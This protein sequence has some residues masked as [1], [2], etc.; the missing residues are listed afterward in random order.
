MDK[1]KNTPE[2]NIFLNV[3]VRIGYNVVEVYLQKKL[4][5]ENIKVEEEDGGVTNYA[6]ILGVSIGK[7]MEE[8]FDIALNLKFRTLTSFFKNKTGSLL[9]HVS[10]EFDERQ[11]GVHIH[12]FKLRGTGKNWFL[13]KTLQ[14]VANTFFHEKL[15]RKMNFDFGPPVKEQLVKI[16]Q[17]LENRLE[18]VQGLFVSG[19]LNKF[20]ITEIIPGQ[21]H[22]L[23]HVVVEANALVDINEI[24]L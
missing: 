19:K 12:D 6:E 11:Q 20:R 15:K 16:N 21:S 24:N 5:G 23:V 10:I 9:L 7:S 3:P 22:F 18:P 8:D 14:A 4:I 2:N 1:V 13:N 17:K